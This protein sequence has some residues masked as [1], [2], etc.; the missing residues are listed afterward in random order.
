MWASP[1]PVALA[2]QPSPLD[3]ARRSAT[4]QGLAGFPLAYGWMNPRFFSAWALTSC[5]ALAE[6]C[7]AV[8]NAFPWIAITRLFAV[9]TPMK[10]AI[11]VP[12][13]SQTSTSKFISSSS[14]LPVP[15]ESM[16]AKRLPGAHPP[17]VAVPSPPFSVAIVASSET[18]STRRNRSGLSDVPADGPKGRRGL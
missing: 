6:S 16:N 11:S 15:H 4:A 13:S 8:L 5:K 2:S 3:S 10:S 14:V 17:P 7:F 12:M 1:F 18:P 9:S